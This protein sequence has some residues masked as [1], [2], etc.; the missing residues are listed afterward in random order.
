MISSRLRAGQAFQLVVQVDEAVVDVHT[1]F[2]EQLA[3]LLE[4]FLVEDLHRVAE[5]D[6][7]RDLHH[8][9]LDVQREHHA[10]LAGVFHLL[11]VE[12]A[13]RLLAHEHA[14]DDLAVQQRHLGLEHNGLTALG[15]QFHLHVAGVVHRHG[16]FA[17]VEVAVLHV[18]HV[19]A[20][21]HA[22]LA[23]AVRILAGV[24]LHGGGRAAVRVALA[25]HG[26]DGAAQAPGVALA[27][28]LLGV[29]LRLLREIRH[30]VAL[31]LQFL[32]RADQ[33]MHRG[34]D[35]GQLDDV[36]IGQQGQTTEFG[37]VVGHP[38]RL[39][40]EFRE[41]AQDAAGHGDVAGGDLD[42]GRRGERADDGQEGT[43]RQQRGLVGQGVDD[44]RLLGTHRLSQDRETV[45]GA[46]GRVTDRHS[47]F[48]FCLISVPSSCNFTRRTPQPDNA[49]RQV[50]FEAAPWSAVVR[51]CAGDR[52][53][54][55]A[56]GVGE[57]T[58]IRRIRGKRPDICVD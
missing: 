58:M 38:L 36:G 25:Q 41:F 26:I 16:L 8:R 37:Q 4:G 1:Q 29:G 2:V 45:L 55:T 20:R 34:T 17:M 56:S 51:R 14:V 13:Q 39:G 52:Y 48:E 21:S 54:W 46:A 3:V 6:G 7:V 11:F 19:G 27:D 30:L 53:G 57:V 40:Q 44:R 23:H 50:G 10:G 49:F 47:C 5:D 31:A 18:G 35:V 22:P 24:V 9:G 32:D 28:G 42:A 15:E 33:L 12:V 43:R